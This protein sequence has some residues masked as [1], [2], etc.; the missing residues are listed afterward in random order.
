MAFT[1]LNFFQ[2]WS[3]KVIYMA[4][5]ANAF[6][7]NISLIQC[8]LL[9]SKNFHLVLKFIFYKIYLTESPFNTYI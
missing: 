2:N 3:W 9:Q 1:S 7:I 4:A 8:Y 6:S 5:F